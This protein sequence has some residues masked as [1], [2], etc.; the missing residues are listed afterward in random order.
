MQFQSFQVVRDPYFDLTSCLLEYF[1]EVLL[2]QLSL[3]G[4]EPN[5]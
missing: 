4:L 1:G 3:V 2:L 5:F